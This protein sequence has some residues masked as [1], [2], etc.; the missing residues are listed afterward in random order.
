MC[1]GCGREQQGHEEA[2][3]GVELIFGNPGYPLTSA[4]LAV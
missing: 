2:G 4:P 3:V 1:V